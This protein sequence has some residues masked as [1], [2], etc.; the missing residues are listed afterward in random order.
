MNKREIASIYLQHLPHP[1]R[2]ISALILW[3]VRSGQLDHKR[4]PF[5]CKLI[6]LS[7]EKL[8]YFLPLWIWKKDFKCE[9]SWAHWKRMGI[10]ESDSQRVYAFV[11][12][13]PSSLPSALSWRGRH[14][15]VVP[16]PKPQPNVSECW[17]KSAWLDR[18]SRSNNSKVICAWSYILTC[19]VD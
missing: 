13:S 10:E 17:K 11:A 4:E 15:S 3:C 8:A 6:S 19:I 5:A 1:I 18:Q 7:D 2:S 9:V 12:S 16:L 14:A